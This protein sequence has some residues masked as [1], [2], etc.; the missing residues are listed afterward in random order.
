[1]GAWVLFFATHFPKMMGKNLPN[2]KTTR[3]P[4]FDWSGKNS[5]AQV[6][7]KTNQ[8]KRKHYRE[9]E[10]QKAICFVRFYIS[11]FIVLCTNDSYFVFFAVSYFSYCVS[12]YGTS[13][14]SH[15]KRP[16]NGQIESA[17]C[18]WE[19]HCQF[20][21]PSLCR[22][23]HLRV[24]LVCY[25]SQKAHQRSKMHRNC[26]NIITVNMSNQTNNLMS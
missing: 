23:V 2:V 9:R 1:M 12:A 3:T 8:K 20:L 11:F 6:K 24:L 17:K 4:S 13:F 14:I 21:S 7:D 25:Y 10:L 16:Q 18:R 22:S 19:C 5:V 26:L 15:N